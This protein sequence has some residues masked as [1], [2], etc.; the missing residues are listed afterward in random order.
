VV[1]KASL[2]PVSPVVQERTREGK[3]ASQ[4][5]LALTSHSFSLSTRL[6]QLD[7]AWQRLELPTPAPEAARS[8]TAASGAANP[9]VM[10]DEFTRRQQL[11]SLLSQPQPRTHG[12]T[13][14]AAGEDQAPAHPASA[15]RAYSQAAGPMAGV[16]LYNS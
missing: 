13:I 9:R 16:R 15:R 3:P 12:L 7:F 2:I 10:R 14:Q 4:E 1:G 8:A 5:S 11:A 6:F